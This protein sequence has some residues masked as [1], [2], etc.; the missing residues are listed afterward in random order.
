MS[1]TDDLVDDET[2]AKEIGLSEVPIIDLAPFLGGTPS[3]RARVAAQIAQACREIGFFYVVGHG[4]PEQLRSD[5]FACAEAFYHK[6]DAEKMSTLA[7]PDWY[8]G[9]IP[10][11]PGTALSRA[12]RLFE[13]F[14][15]Q[16][17]LPPDDPDVRA[18]SP[19]Y[20]P[21]RW[22]ADM[23]GFAETCNRYY[24]AM[25]ALS[26]H[27]LR[28]FALGLGLPEDRFEGMF[29]KPLS[30]LSLQYYP[31]L[32]EAAE[33]DVSN[34][35]SHTDEGPLTILAQGRVSGLEVKRR[36][37]TWIAAP[38]VEGAY[39]INVGDMLMWWSNGRYLSN[40]HR[41]RNR[42]GVERFSVPFF[43]N[44]DF[45]TVVEPLP[46]LLEAGDAP[47]HEPVRVGEHLLRFYASFKT[48]PAA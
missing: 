33:K 46:E 44:P 35:R 48:Q 28:A 26:R 36:D 32:P 22:P 21:N 14:R 18:G 43:M 42:A 1:R 9:W 25:V 19:L 34:T 6:D 38:P 24:D 3:D 37:G 7:T 23:P 4:V 29:N 5:V 20:Q 45:E 2:Q 8:R 16:A 15:M 41:V 39:T 47:I 10:A 40:L 27:L 12:S 30:Q 17:D 31:P 11:Q 13:Q